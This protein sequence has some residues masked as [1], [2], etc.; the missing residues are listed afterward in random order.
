VQKTKQMLEV[1]LLVVPH[2]EVAATV[3]APTLTGYLSLAFGYSSMFLAAAAITTVGM[4]AMLL[5]RP[6][7]A[8]R[9]ACEEVA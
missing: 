8:G 5:V 1:N 6:G 4:A 2:A 3:L 7:S 9:V